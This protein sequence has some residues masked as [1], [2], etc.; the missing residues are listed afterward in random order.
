ML[1]LATLGGAFKGA[2]RDLLQH[3]RQASLDAVLLPMIYKRVPPALAA[4]GSVPFDF[5]AMVKSNGEA[6]LLSRT[7]FCLSWSRT[8]F[9][10]FSLIPEE[11][12]GP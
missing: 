12:D 9:P 7:A 10:S 5:S 1:S 4:S 2:V 11:I 8:R 3:L 6:A